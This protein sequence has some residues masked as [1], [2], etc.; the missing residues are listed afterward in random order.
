MI[1]VA[2]LRAPFAFHEHSWRAQSVA[3]SGN[4][5]Q[6][7]CY[8]TSRAVQN[9]LDDVCGPAGWGSSFTETA[10]GRVIATISIDMGNRWVDKSDGA[11]ATAMEGEKGGMSGAFKR[12]GVMWGIGRYLY[13]LP[14]VWA[15]CEVVRKNGEMILRN[16]KP[17]WQ[18][19][20]PKGI[21]QMERALSDLFERLNDGQEP[22]RVAGR[23]AQPLL[24]SPDTTPA[25]TLS[26]APP[27]RQP[28]VVTDL[29][30]GLPA[31]MRD[32]QAEE[33]WATHWRSIPEMWRPFVKAERDRL[34]QG[35][36]L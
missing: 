20:T 15:E 19:W 33:F 10:A 31:A 9:R 29:L 36:G 28:L 3:R 8:I 7:L 16:G 24:P 17:V 6:A 12:A 2:A 5:A 25:V 1:D 13:D 22:S 21:A 35:A 4:S 26:L 34:K 18:R 30:E 14:V 27:F 32:G 23:R 11:G